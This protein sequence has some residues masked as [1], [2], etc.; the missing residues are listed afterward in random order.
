MEEKRTLIQ[1][2]RA[3]F[4]SLVKLNLMFVVAC[5]PIITI[6]PALLTLF[7][8]ISEMLHKGTTD[9]K[10]KF[11]RVFFKHIKT[12][13]ATELLFIAFCLLWF[14]AVQFYL[15]GLQENLIYGLMLSSVMLAGILGS[16]FFIYFIVIASSAAL[17]LREIIRFSV[18]LGIAKPAKALASLMIVILIGILGSIFPLYMIPFFLLIGFSGLALCICR[19]IQAPLKQFVLR[20]TLPA[21]PPEQFTET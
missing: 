10:G 9:L 16:Q 21:Q 11:Q 5:I 17:K 2:I 12:G 15:A 7:E 19:L 6:G 18:L 1:I 20:K 8:L 3:Q 4:A 14:V 13:I